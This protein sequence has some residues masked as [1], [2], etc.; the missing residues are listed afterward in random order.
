MEP[1]DKNVAGNNMMI[2]LFDSESF[3]VLLEFT[4]FNMRLKRMVLNS[5]VGKHS[6][7]NFS[8]SGSHLS[9]NL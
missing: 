1:T 7:N 6:N 3:S 4:E 9:D 2:S 5:V 8:Y